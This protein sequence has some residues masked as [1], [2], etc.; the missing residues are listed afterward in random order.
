MWTTYPQQQG[1]GVGQCLRL[2]LTQSQGNTVAISQLQSIF[3]PPYEK[4]YL[5]AVEFW[6]RETTAFSFSTVLPMGVIPAT[7]KRNSRRRGKNRH[8]LSIFHLWHWPRS[9]SQHSS[10]SAKPRCQKQP[11]NHLGS[12]K[13]K[14]IFAQMICF[15]KPL[16]PPSLWK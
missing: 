14:F 15:P 16:I 11:Q 1:Q 4:Y 13:G 3:F 5:F 7:V 10:S 6:Y 8:W 2:L 9:H 12:T